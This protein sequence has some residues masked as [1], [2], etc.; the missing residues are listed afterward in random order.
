MGKRAGRKSD[1]ELPAPK[2]PA[3]ADGAE[4]TLPADVTG[5][6]PQELLSGH[7]PQQL[8]SKMWPLT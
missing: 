2:E 8:L 5:S 6:V 4:E 3:D 1:P 7:A